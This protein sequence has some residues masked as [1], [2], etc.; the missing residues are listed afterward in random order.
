MAKRRV[1]ANDVY[2][3][4]YWYDEKD[5]PFYSPDFDDFEDDLKERFPAVFHAYDY[6]TKSEQVFCHVL[7]SVQDEL[8]VDELE[9]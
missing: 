8:A 2:M 3:M 5:D 6:I 4:R 1:T 9:D 7:D